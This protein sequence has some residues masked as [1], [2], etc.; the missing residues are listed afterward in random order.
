MVKSFITLVHSGKLN[1]IVIYNGTA[2]IHDCIL[3]L[4]NVGTAVNYCSIFI[5]LA[6]VAFTIKIYMII[7]L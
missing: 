1:T 2:K 4:E 6:P 5:T 7:V 3:I